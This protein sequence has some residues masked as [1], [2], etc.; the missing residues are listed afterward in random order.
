MS[1]IFFSVVLTSYNSEKFIKKTLESLI[2]QNF[3][4]FEVILIDDGSA[5]NTVNIAKKIQIRKK[6]NLNIIQLKHSGLPARSRNIGIKRSK[7]RYICFLD[8]DDYFNF[9]KLIYLK[10]ILSKK[11]TDVLY[12]NVFLSKEKKILYC[13][14]I[15]IKNPFSDLFLNKNKIVMSSSVVNR[16]FI[17]KNKIKFNEKKKLVTVE[18]YDFWLQI[19]KSKGKFLLI[20]KILGVYNLNNSSISKKR[21]LHF[22]NTMYLISRYEKYF[23][24]KKLGVFYRKLRIIFSFMR[25]ALTENNFKFLFS[26]MKYKND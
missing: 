23:L 7:G 5:D 26:F 9:N 1:N 22:N 21:Y 18:D 4:N 19:A 6:I 24:S 25:I 14:S 10:R 16:S 13:D 11:K 8:A 15:D 12:H 3:K 17:N 2:G 20:K